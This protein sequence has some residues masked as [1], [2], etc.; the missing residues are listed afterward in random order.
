MRRE[1][2]EMK[3]REEH[4]EDYN[5]ILQLTY[6]AFLTLD[7]PG[8]QRV[9]EHYLVS[10]LQGSSFIIPMFNIKILAVLTF[11]RSILTKPPIVVPIPIIIC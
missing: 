5:S 3:I 10:L 1:V 2:P 8:R 4:P 11:P 9:D 6:E 7:Y